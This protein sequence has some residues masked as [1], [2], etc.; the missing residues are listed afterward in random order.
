MTDMK[1][2]AGLVA[3]VTGG[4]RASAPQLYAN[5]TMNGP[6]L[7]LRRQS[8]TRP[9]PTRSLINTNCWSM[10]LPSRLGSQPTE[11]KPNSSI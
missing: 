3:I 5:L 1:R 2:F 6:G 10:K 11:S 9:L 7:E 4:A 8:L